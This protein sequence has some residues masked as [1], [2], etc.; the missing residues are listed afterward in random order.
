MKSVCEIGRRLI[1][2]N[3]FSLSHGRSKGTLPVVPVAEPPL[4]CLAFSRRLLVSKQQSQV[5]Y[6]GD[7]VVFCEMGYEF[8]GLFLTQDMSAESTETHFGY[9]AASKPETWHF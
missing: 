1:W 2:G 3:I 5:K 7:S 4:T 8:R 9:R 6:K